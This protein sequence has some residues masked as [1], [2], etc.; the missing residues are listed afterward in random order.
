MTKNLHFK[1]NYKEDK[2]LFEF[3]VGDKIE[4]MSPERFEVFVSQFSS[5]MS[6]CRMKITLDRP[7]EARLREYLELVLSSY[8]NYENNKLKEVK[9]KDDKCPM[10]RDFF[11]KYRCNSP[12]EC[13]CPK[14]QG[15][16]ECEEF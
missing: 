5:P 15:L 7:Q 6:V 10:C 8:K 9:D 2:K 14:C 4:F 1:V 13:D 3:S 11:S 16:C 12:E